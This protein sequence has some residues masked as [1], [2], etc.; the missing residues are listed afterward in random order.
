MSVITF[1]NQIYPDLLASGGTRIHV[2]GGYTEESSHFKNPLIA[3][4]Q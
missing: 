2:Y 3:W 1:D 4:G